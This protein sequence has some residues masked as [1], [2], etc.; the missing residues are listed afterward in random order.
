MPPPR[1]RAFLRHFLP[2]KRKGRGPKQADPH[3]TTQNLHTPDSSLIQESGVHYRLWYDHWLAQGAG[4]RAE[5]SSGRSTS[6]RA[7]PS[8]K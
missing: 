3:K 2:G 7:G 1:W 8:Q 6:R 5:K 4:D